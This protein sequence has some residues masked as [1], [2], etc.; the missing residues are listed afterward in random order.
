MRLTTFA[1]FVLLSALVWVRPDAA[2]PVPVRLVEGA[3]HGFLVL[4]T[5]D[6]AALASGDLRQTTSSQGVEAR[7]VFNFKDGSLSEETVVF[8]QQRAFSLQAYHLLQRGP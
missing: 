1:L 4:K 6:G 7:T 2:S 5:S 8:S 3:I